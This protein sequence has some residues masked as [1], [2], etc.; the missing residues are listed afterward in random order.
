MSSVCHTVSLIQIYGT[1]GAVSLLH[2]LP[3]SLTRA[4]RGTGPGSIWVCQ[5]DPY[6]G[7]RSLLLFL[8]CRWRMQT[9]LSVDSSRT[10]T[11]VYRWSLCMKTEIFSPSVHWVES[12]EALWLVVSARTKRLKVSNLCKCNVSQ[13]AMT[14]C[15]ILSYV[16]P[17]ENQI[18]NLKLIHWQL[19]NW[20]SR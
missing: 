7:A 1:G 19:Q 10:I 13:V 3:H 20:R 15:I 6:Y 2:L 8:T 14:C 18:L 9:F 5:I 16:V 4:R 11:T 17:T 12:F